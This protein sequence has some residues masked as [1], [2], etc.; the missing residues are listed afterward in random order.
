MK[1]SIITPSYNQASYIEQTIKSVLEQDYKNIEYIIMDGGSTDG[2]VEILKKYSDKI[3]WRSEKDK[4]QSD[5]INKG[6]RLATG[7][8][9]AFI[10][11]DDTYEPGAIRKVVN[12]FNKNKEAK[13]VFGKCHIIDE[14][15]KEIRKFITSYKNFWLNFL[16]YFWL[17]ALNPISQP[18]TF[19]K[20][21]IHSEE[22]YFDKDLHYAMDYDFW[23]RIGRRNDFHYLPKYLA[24]FRWHTQSK[25]GMV[26]E[27][28]FKE[29]YDLAKKY[30][31]KIG[32]IFPV[33]LHKLNEL[34]II[35]IYRIIKK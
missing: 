31:K 9:V 15:G 19:W 13:W 7:E 8:I 3:I 26:Y 11:S 35:S 21:Q 16:N 12:F 32:R 25:G 24:S 33:W 18:A 22:G 4:G 6:L 1:V 34:A 27:K 10:N 20:R 14:N 5:G 29:E 23:L 2:T 30:A 28:Q 17:L